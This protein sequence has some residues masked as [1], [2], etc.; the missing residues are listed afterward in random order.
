MRSAP[1][2]R[3]ARARRAAA[4]WTGCSLRSG[5][6]RRASRRGRS[7]PPADRGR[8]RGRPPCSRPARRRAPRPARG[9]P[10]R[11]PAPA[12]PVASSGASRTAGAGASGTAP[13]AGAGASSRISEPSETVSPTATL[14]SATVP[15][16]GAGMSIVALSDSSVMSGSS[17]ATSSPARDQHLDDRH[18]GE[19]ADV[20]DLHLDEIGHQS[21]TLRR[22]VSTAA[23]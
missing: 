13:S 11:A 14:S 6:R 2:T 5:T 8:R 12:A 23:R 21:S 20:G 10:R 3:R 1:R 19:V 15:A 18:V 22:S 17:A 4:P 16:R 9:R 7:A